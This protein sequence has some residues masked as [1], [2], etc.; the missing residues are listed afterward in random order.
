MFESTISSDEYRKRRE[1]LCGQI[2]DA[3]AL[4]VGAPAPNDRAPFR[5]YND[6]C[7]L[8]GVEVPQSYLLIDGRTGH[9]SLFLPES[10]QR[11]RERNDELL[12]AD[13][14]DVARA[15]TGVD[16]VQRRDSLSEALK[17][18][19]RLYTFLR[20][21]EG[22]K[23]DVRSIT[24]AS[25]QIEEDP[26]DGRPNRGGHFVQRLRA[27]LPQIEIEDI[28]PVLLSMRMIKSQAEVALLR[29][30][31]R[32]SAAG[33]VDAMR[34]TRPGVMEYQLAAVLQ[35]HYLAGGAGDNS[36]APIVASGPNIIHPHYCANNCELRDGDLVLVD[37]APDYHYYTSD[38]TRMWPVNGAY[39]AAQRALY[40]FVTEFHKVLLGAIVPGRACADIEEDAAEQM[41]RRLDEFDFASPGHRAG[42]Q[43]MCSSR[44]HI[45]HSVGMSVH[46]GLGHK[47]GALQ[48]SMV[49]AVDPQLWLREEGLY[50]RVEDTG[51]VT[52]DGFDVFTKD[53]PLEL[54]D[55][56]KLISGDGVL[57]TFPL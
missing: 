14:P 56:E 7:Y 46:D 27:S 29:R 1:L 51:V 24:D 16:E 47:E 20:D 49:F 54:D 12:V 26:W 13:R 37:C 57:R 15:L 10:A 18:V 4:V 38:I 39:T 2:G 35:Y 21:G 42:A 40:G 33:L 23:C 11:S 48:P 52:E 5:Q 44:N 55:I 34:A 28:S 53:A 22:R 50:I 31:G 17:G 30:A 25:R 9:A 45:A 41:L 43:K 8:C 32:L 36:Y 3:H 6:F 19:R